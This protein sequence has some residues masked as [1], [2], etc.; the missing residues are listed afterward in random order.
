MP[1]L[2]GWITQQIDEV[3]R[4]AEADCPD[5]WAA[6]AL[7]RCSADRKIL[8]RHNIDPERA[9]WSRSEAVACRGCGTYSD[10]DWPVTDNLNDCPELLDLA[11]GYGLT[12]DQLAQ[13]DRPEL[14]PRQEPSVRPEWDVWPMGVIQRTTPTSAVPAALRGPNWK[15]RA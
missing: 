14:P 4:A 11:E 8:A 3:E 1:D 5:P 6:T 10:C 12:E 13:L 2:H 15:P 9:K 7:R